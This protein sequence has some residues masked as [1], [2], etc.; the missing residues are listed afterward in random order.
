MWTWLAAAN[1]TLLYA[2]MLL[3]SGSAL[4]RP[5]MRWPQVVLP[6][7]SAQGRVAALG[8]AADALRR[9]I[10]FEYGLIILILVIAV[11]LTMALPPRMAPAGDAA[12]AGLE[13]VGR[14]A[15]KVSPEVQIMR[16]KLAE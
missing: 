7:I 16:S 1:R 13:G 6:A 3:A 8:A 10:R 14:L 5:L 2:T 15:A 4:L 9:S 12:A 11:A